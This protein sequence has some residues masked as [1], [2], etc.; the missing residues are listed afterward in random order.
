MG[1]VEKRESF[2]KEIGR[3]VV[4]EAK[5]TIGF[6]ALGSRILGVIGA[7][8]GLS[9]FGLIGLAIGSIVGAIAGGVI[10]FM[11]YLDS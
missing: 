2:T 3:E 10:F 5:S 6:V 8:A 1:Q 4:D 11:A 9:Y 7:G